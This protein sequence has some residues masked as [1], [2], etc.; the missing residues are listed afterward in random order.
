MDVLVQLALCAGAVV[1]RETLIDAIWPGQHVEDEGLT[2]CI[3]ELRDALGEDARQPS[4]VETIP[5]RGYRL[6]V[7]V[8]W[9][10][11]LPPTVA[12]RA[13]GVVVLPV[14]D[15]GP[16][17]DESFSMG[18]TEALI[19]VLAR[20]PGLRVVSRTSTTHVEPGMDLQAIAGKFHVSH[21]LE[22]SVR[23]AGPRTVITVRLMDARGEEAVWSETYVDQSGDSLEIQDRTARAVADALIP[24]LQGFQ[25]R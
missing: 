23:R 7:P 16:D 18:L 2:H 6:S 13:H 5:K 12:S 19:T 4:L 21:A 17:H 8:Q 22:S 11:H 9:T 20:V 3:A 15:L 10:A 24:L 25:A 1:P 14:D